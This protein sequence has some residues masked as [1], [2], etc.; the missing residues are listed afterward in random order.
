MFMILNLAG[1]R[2]RGRAGPVRLLQRDDAGRLRES[3]VRGRN[4]YAVALA[5]TETGERQPQTGN[6]YSNTIPAA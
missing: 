5:T 1:G 4:Y 2:G 6:L 3:V